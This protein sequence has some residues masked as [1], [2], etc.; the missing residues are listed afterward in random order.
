ML[1][2]PKITNFSR[3]GTKINAI[4]MRHIAALTHRQAEDEFPGGGIKHYGTAD[5]GHNFAA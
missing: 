4:D 3:N 5:D 1:S 2:C